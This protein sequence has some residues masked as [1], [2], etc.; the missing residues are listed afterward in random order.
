VSY[1]DIAALRDMTE[2]ECCE[3][4]TREIG[5]TPIPV[6]AFYSSAAEQQI[7][8]FCFAKREETLD[9][10]LVRLGRL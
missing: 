8:R 2:R 10:A 7:V 6:S 9:A 5:V 1:A 4:L 3:W